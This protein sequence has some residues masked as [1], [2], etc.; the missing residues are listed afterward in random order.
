M[1][2]KDTPQRGDVLGEI[3]FFDDRVGPN[4]LHQASLS[5]TSR[6][7]RPGSAKSQRHAA[8]A[9]PPCHPA[10]RADVPPHPRGNRRIRRS[11]RESGASSHEFQRNFSLILRT[12][13]IVGTRLSS[14]RTNNPTKQNPQHQKEQRS[15]RKYKMQNSLKST[16]SLCSS[17]RLS[18][19]PR[20]R[21][22]PGR[23]VRSVN[24]FI[25]TNW[26]NGVPNLDQGTDGVIANGGTALVTRPLADAKPFRRRS[27]GNW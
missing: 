1:S 20:P 27:D 8:L 6:C 2:P 14:N 24:R 15:E 10:E 9:P 23:M 3:V 17:S 21:R 16:W 13:R 18:L 22:P 12:F 19:V 7:A 5:S 25:A 11:A 26:S 4:R